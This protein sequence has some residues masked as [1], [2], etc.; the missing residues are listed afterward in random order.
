MANGFHQGYKYNCNTYKWGNFTLFIP[1]QQGPT[2]ISFIVL[3]SPLKIN[4]W[5]ITFPF[6]SSL[7]WVHSVDFRCGGALTSPKGLRTTTL[8][9]CIHGGV[10][11]HNSGSQLPFSHLSPEEFDPHRP[12]AKTEALE[13]KNLSNLF[14]FGEFAIIFVHIMQDYSNC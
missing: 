12:R 8:G 14:W 1:M 4:D 2:S 13:G 6:E 10:K 5:K 11:I 7:F 3:T 9:T